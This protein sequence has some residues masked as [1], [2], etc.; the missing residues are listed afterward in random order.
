MPA[1][2]YR[3]YFPNGKHDAGT[4]DASNVQEAARELARRGLRPYQLTAVSDKHARGRSTPK[5]IFSRSVDLGKLF[6]DLSVLL[7]AGFTIDRS[8][9]AIIA[10]ETNVSR[11]KSLQGILDLTTAG[12][13]VAQAFSSLEKIPADVIALLASGERSGKL[14][15]VCERLAEIYEARAKRRSAIVSAF[16]YP[17]FL[18][19]VTG[20]AV[21]VLAF[22]LV[23]ALE[24]IFEG[25]STPP[26]LTIRLL[27]GLAAVVT[28]Y[29]F[30]FPLIAIIVL[31]GFLAASRSATAKKRLFGWCLGIPLAGPLFKQA[32]TARYLEALALLLANGVAMTEALRLATGTVGS[33][34]LA[35][36][37]GHL[38]NDV[39]SGTRLNEAL[40]KSKMFG[41]SIVSLVALGEDAN[42][43][44]LMLERAA[45][46][47]QTELS[48]RIENLLKLLT[49]A[50]TI[51]L[52]VL[53]GSLVISVMTTI[54][55]I[56][57]LALK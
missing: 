47:L 20:A 30:I 41:A 32:I 33:S 12:R 53:V 6:S 18:L 24:P 52:G 35:Q 14:P 39:G 46:M 9:A 38:E 57:D 27:S 19:A 11:R 31:F 10:S 45:R 51:L 4:L 49:P 42:A 48:K 17:I 56:N 50:L 55:S 8:I 2:A 21:L 15:L 23:P 40:G 54:L 25:S 26:P 16:A 37:L 3:A 29:P 43:L 28:E 34:P 5:S 44:P 7:N 36:D 22:V 1:F 13:S